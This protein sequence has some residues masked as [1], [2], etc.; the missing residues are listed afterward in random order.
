MGSEPERGTS[1]VVAPGEITSPCLAPT[2]RLPSEHQG[3]RLTACPDLSLFAH[4]QSLSRN[5]GGE[6]LRTPDALAEL[7]Q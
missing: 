6:W 4:C 2:A 3:R 1:A 5:L 7:D